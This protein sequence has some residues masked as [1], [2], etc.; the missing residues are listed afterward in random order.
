MSTATQHHN[1]RNFAWLSIAAALA[2]I[3]LKVGAWQLTGSVGLLSDA[4]ESGVN[5]VAAIVALI[6]LTIAA[7]EPD[8]EHAYGHGKAEYFSSG[9]EGGLIILAAVGIF[10][11]AIPRLLQPQE[12]ERVGIGLAIAVI[13][14]IINGLVG[15]RL[16]IAARQTRS[17]VLRADAHHL[18]TDVW[19]SVGVVAG[20]ALVAFTGW[21]RLDAIIAIAIGINIIFTGYKLVNASIH[22]LLDT[23]IPMEDLDK[24]ERVLRRYQMEHDIVTHALRTRESGTRRFVSMHVLVPGDWTVRQGH[25]LVGAI[26][27]DIR[28]VLPETTVFTHLEPID[29]PESWDDAGL[30]G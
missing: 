9:V 13:A 29:E 8:E 15:W 19:T 25:D 16:M 14:A 28:D 17:I 4:L 7:R 24:V 10:I 30:D 11:S 12:I 5:L 18:F 21:L 1:P 22:G 2:T 27:R 23:A 6:A 26:E 3:I 20:V